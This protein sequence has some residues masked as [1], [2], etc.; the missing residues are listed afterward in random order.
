[1][2]PAGMPRPDAADA[3][4]ARLV[5]RERRSIARRPSVPNPGR[6]VA[7]PAEPRRVR[8]RHPRPAGARGRL[9]RR[10]CRRTIRPTAST[11]TPTCSAS[12]RRCSS[13][14]CR[15]RR[16]SARWPSASPTIIAGIGDLPRSRR[17]VADRPGRGAAAGHARRPDGDCT[18]S[19]STASTS[20]R[21]S[22]SRPTSARS[23]ASSTSTSSRSPWTAS[24]CCSRRSAV[25]RT[26]RESSLNAT[27]VVNSL[28]ERL[29]VR[30]Q[31]RAGQRP[32]GA[33]FLQ[34][35]PALGRESGCSRFC[36]ARSIATDHLGLPHV[37]NMT[38]TGP[39]NATGAGETPSRRRVF[40]CRPAQAPA[41][42]RG[43]ARRRILSTLARRAYRRPV[44]DADL[45]RPDG[46]LRRRAT[47]GTASTRHRAGAAR[48]C[49]SARSSCSASSAIR[50]ASRRAARIAISD[51]ELASRLSF[52]LW[53]SIPDDELLDVAEPRAGCASPP[54]STRRCGA[55]WP[56]R[57]RRRWSTTSP[58]SGCTSATCA[59]RR[60]TRTTFPT[61]TTT[62]GRRSSAR[63]SCS[64][65]ASSREDRSVLDLLTADYT[66]VNERLARHYG[67][68]QR[69]RQP[70][71]PRHAAPTRRGEGLLG[72][73]GILL[74]DVARRSHVAGGARQVD[75]RQ[76]ARHAAAAAAGRRAAV[77][78][79]RSAARRRP[80]ARG[81]SSTAR[82]R[83]ARAATR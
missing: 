48:R 18:R 24:A 9:R 81:W 73:G 13:A 15:R 68:P 43:R 53:S 49:W 61:S 37:E 39:F 1:M 45:T 26:T 46:V 17:R 75:S 38:V 62:C 29:Q 80:C 8:E 10:C 6:P 21:S 72:K 60:R 70:L 32:V 79:R 4:R 42:E 76:P 41:D 74:R 5:S 50:P 58:G 47:R 14:T 33:A 83:R 63:S 30:V 82:T 36:A 78:G 2:P 57:A 59:A 16:R 20:S 71:P 34:K 31:V 28:D 65:A 67:I 25:P 3:R 66:F 54:C 27:N 22:C 44:T 11:T 23:A 52:F 40:V 77:P 35:P 12:R 19:R 55:C 64:S 56:I 7:A 51:L 69:L